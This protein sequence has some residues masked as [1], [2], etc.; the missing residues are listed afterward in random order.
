MDPNAALKRLVQ[1]SEQLIDE[2]SHE[3]AY[4]TIRATELAETFLAL[5]EWLRKG[6]FKPHPWIP[7][8]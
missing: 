8:Q 4:L 7:K 5:D 2:P 3:Y 1:L 6:G